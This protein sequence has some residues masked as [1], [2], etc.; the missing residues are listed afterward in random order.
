ML[1]PGYLGGVKAPG[2]NAAAKTASG[3]A[4][5][6]LNAG[7]GIRADPRDAAKS[8]LAT[9]A[10]GRCPMCGN[11]CRKTPIT[12]RLQAWTPM[13]EAAVRAAYTGPRG[14]GGQV[15]R[16]DPAHSQ[17]E[18]AAIQRAEVDLTE[19]P[20]LTCARCGFAGLDPATDAL[21]GEAR[22]SLTIA[23]GVTA[24]P[25]ERLPTAL[26]KEATPHVNPGNESG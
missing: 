25:W 3:T 17:S 13:L 19:V 4:S 7:V 11:R 2:S 6:L 21:L 16:P 23:I 8:Q 9:T 26:G 24:M 18:P 14:P 5:Q 10:D 20:A 15:Q 1:H 22:Q 12:V